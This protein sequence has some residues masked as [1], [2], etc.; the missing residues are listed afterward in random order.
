MLSL[1][2]SALVGLTITI[3][4]VFIQTPM[5]HLGIDVVYWG[6]PLPWSMRVIPTRIHSIDPFNFVSDVVFWIAT[7]SG[8]LFD[9]RYLRTDWKAKNSAGQSKVN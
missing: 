6:L 2:A 5:T 8:C 7:T 1:I 3:V 9:I 4:S